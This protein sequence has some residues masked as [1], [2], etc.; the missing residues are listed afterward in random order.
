MTNESL[1]SVN[2]LLA[3]REVKKAEVLIARALRADP[4]VSE[5]AAL[6]IM[7]ARTRLYSSRLDDALTDLGEARALLPVLFEPPDVLEL[8]GDVHFARFEL[9]SVGFAD[10]TDAEKALIA[11]DSILQ[12]H[13]DYA[14][15]GWIEYQKGRVLLT[16]NRVDE[17]I[18]AFQRALF[19]PSR[20]ATLT[21]Y[22]Y[23]RLGFIAFYEQRDMRQALA[24]LDKAVSTY[25][26]YEPRAWLV[27]VNVLRSRI[28]RELHDYAN[29]FEAARLALA[30]A[31]NSGPQGKL[32]LADA[33]VA[34][35]EI[36]CAL[37]GREREGIALLQTFVAASR[38]PV[39]ID[40]TWSR[41]HE[42]LGDAQFKIGDPTSALA[43]Y[44]AALQFN[45]YHP[46]ELSLYHRIARCYYQL[47]EYDRAIA[48][49]QTMLNTAQRDGDP[50]RDH[51]I[52]QLLG[53][54]EYALGRYP[55]AAQSYKTALEL[56]PAAH[57]SVH[58]I[59]RYYEVARTHRRGRRGRNQ[60]V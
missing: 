40:V 23:E 52:Y 55:Q 17:A 24:F 54:S 42:M 11:Y 7:R 38:K 39:G 4:T 57:D 43:S 36:A 9:A 58:T 12:Y 29:A 60:P 22:C 5:R 28:L 10:R 34:A 1:T 32:S 20:F 3:R 26:P 13:L 35:G 21:A 41:V 47:K 14:N 49:L 16:E 27:Q 45:P 48:A 2:E 56:A 6:L 33:A 59:R 31:Q 53:N 19:A 44:Q 30:I 25:P 8:V 51:R 15:S 18:A 50:V 46:W 37:E